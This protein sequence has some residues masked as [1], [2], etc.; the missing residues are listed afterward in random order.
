MW[1]G[2]GAF[3][4]VWALC[5]VSWALILIYLVGAEKS[6][7]MITFLLTDSVVDDELRTAGR[8]EGSEGD[9][10]RGSGGIYSWWRW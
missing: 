5:A 10:W 9:Q 8:G 3:W 4:I 2:F 7:S 6:R 1:R